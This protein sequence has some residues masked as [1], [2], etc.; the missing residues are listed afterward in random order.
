MR[1]L[2]WFVYIALVIGSGKK[3]QGCQTFNML[4]ETS[5]VKVVL[6]RSCAHTINLTSQRAEKGLSGNQNLKFMI[7]L[8]YSSV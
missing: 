5:D 4:H 1:V 8:I 2:Q 3:T 6:T 7:K